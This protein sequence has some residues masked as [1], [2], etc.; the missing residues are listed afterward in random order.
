MA[1]AP[2]Q[3]RQPLSTRGRQLLFGV[4]FLEGDTRVVRYFT[5]DAEADAAIAQDSGVV[6]RALSAGC[7]QSEEEFDEML[8]EL[9]RIRH[10][11]P[12]TPLPEPFPL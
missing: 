1:E 5:S 6:E 7:D 4:P 10:R 12:P 9:D 8:D 11:N 2:S 3:T